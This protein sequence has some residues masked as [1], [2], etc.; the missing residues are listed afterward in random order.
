MRT[1][2]AEAQEELTNVLFK[3]KIR[4]QLSLWSSCSFTATSYVVNFARDEE[5]DKK[6]TK[7]SSTTFPSQVSKSCATSNI[8]MMIAPR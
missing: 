3:I 7:F 2:V 5:N 4:V 1:I 8:P 6:N